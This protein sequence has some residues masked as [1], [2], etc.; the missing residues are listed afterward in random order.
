[1]HFYH[2]NAFLLNKRYLSFLSL[3]FQG[4]I[5]E[6]VFSILRFAFSFENQILQALKSIN[7]IRLFVFSDISFENQILLKD[8]PNKYTVNENGNDRKGEL[9]FR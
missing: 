3:P 7:T 4:Y 8:K 9:T 6:V 1:M 2:S 5:K